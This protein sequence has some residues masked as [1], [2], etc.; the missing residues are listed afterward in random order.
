MNSFTDYNSNSSKKGII[1][2]LVLW[3]LFFLSVTV[4]TLSF[5]NRLS[6]KLRSLYNQQMQMHYLAKE[7]INRA[8][9]KLAQDDNN[10]DSRSEVWAEDFTL[11]KEQGLL[12]CKVVDEDR[13]IN[14]NTATEE[15]LEN[16][17]L[18]F[19]Q[20]SLQNIEKLIKNRPFNIN[21]EIKAIINQDKEDFNLI[22]PQTTSIEDLVTTFSDGR[23]NI[24][25]APREVLLM[26]PGIKEITVDTI[27]NH[28]DIEAFIANETLSEDLSLLGLSAAQ[29]SALI[30]Y[31]KVDSAVFRIAAQAV[32]KTKNISKNI[33]LVLQRKDHKFK[34][35][36]FQEN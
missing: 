34:M 28:R 33:N 25:T 16:I 4:L 20:I 36:M 9:I 10:F 21:G 18:I 15:M 26:I 14:I 17:Q 3:I 11:Q 7:G 29:V 6:I 5:R 8:I 19:P 2:A 30:K 22:Q 12:L 35:L 27:I 31:V 32:S 1:L 13:F 23:I 24:N